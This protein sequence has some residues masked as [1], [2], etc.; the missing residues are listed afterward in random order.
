MNTTNQWM[1]EESPT[2]DTLEDP[3]LWTIKNIFFERKNH[4][5]FS[6]QRLIWLYRWLDMNNYDTI[7]RTVSRDT[8]EC[9]QNDHLIMPMIDKKIKLLHD[10]WCKEY[11]HP[12]LTTNDAFEIISQNNDKYVIALSSTRPGSLRISYW[13]EGVKHHRID[14]NTYTTKEYSEIIDY[15][16]SRFEFTIEKIIQKYDLTKKICEYSS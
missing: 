2:K 11:F 4:H 5:S 6:I 13:K 15:D 7:D 12:F 8:V 16:V 3:K 14:L 9:Y 10:I 1:S